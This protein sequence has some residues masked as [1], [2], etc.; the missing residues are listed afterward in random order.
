[1]GDAFAVIFFLPVRV[2][3]TAHKYVNR[4]KKKKKNEILI[5]L[6]LH[7]TWKNICDSSIE[8]SWIET[9]MHSCTDL[10]ASERKSDDT[11]LTRTKQTDFRSE[12]DENARFVFDQTQTFHD[13]QWIRVGLGRGQRKITF[14]FNKLRFSVSA[15]VSFY[16]YWIFFL[17]WMIDSRA[18]TVD[19]NT[20]CLHSCSYCIVQQL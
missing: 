14:S 15:D 4:T 9:R 16:Y 10:L 12:S 20:C 17:H 19:W 18:D 8:S 3:I 7:S 2:V 1:M 6:F 5:S 13:L 11:L